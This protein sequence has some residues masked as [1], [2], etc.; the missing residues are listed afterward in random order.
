VNRREPKDGAPP[1]GLDVDMRRL[2]G[3]AVLVGVDAED[4]RPEPV[5]DGHAARLDQ[6]AGG[7]SHGAQR[8]FTTAYSELDTPMPGTALVHALRYGVVVYER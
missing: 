6:G 3:L 2:M 8:R 4:V 1:C 5:D 7:W